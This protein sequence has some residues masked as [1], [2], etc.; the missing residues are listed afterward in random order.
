MGAG[1]QYHLNAA[2]KV[3]IGWIPA[4]NVLPVSAEGNYTIYPVEKTASGP[5]ALAIR[6]PDSNEEYYIDYRQPI[7]FD[8]TL[9]LGIISGASVI[10]TRPYQTSAT[11]YY[12]GLHT[13]RIDATPGDNDFTNS[14]L[15]DGK[16]FIDTMNGVTVTQ[17]SHNSTSATVNVKFGA[18]TC[19]KSLPSISISPA[20]QKGVSGQ[21]LNYVATIK[22]NDSAT[23]PNLRFIFSGAV[24]SGWKISMS[25]SELF[26][27]PGASGTVSVAVTSPTS[28][29]AGDYQ[30]IFNAVDYRNSQNKAS[31]S[32][33]Y[34]VAADTVLPSVAIKS[35]VS[36]S[37][38]SGTVD[39][40]AQVSDNVGVKKMEFYVN[41]VL[42]N[43]DLAAPFSYRWNTST[44]A[45]GNYVLTVKAYDLAGNSKLSDPIGVVVDS[46]YVDAVAPAVQISAPAAGSVVR[47]ITGVTAIASDN[48][49]VTKIEFYINGKLVSTDNAAD[50]Y[51]SWNTKS[52]ATPY[53][54]GNYSL[55]AKAYDVAGNI[56][57]SPAIGVT[58]NNNNS[59]AYSIKITTPLDGSNIS[60]TIAI[61]AQASGTTLY[62]VEYYANGALIGTAPGSP[63]CINWNSMG[64]PNGTYS[65]TAKLYNG[66]VNVAAISSPVSVNVS[67]GG[68]LDKSAPI[69]SLVAPA[70]SSTISGITDVAVSASDNNGVAGV[71]FFINGDLV[72]FDASAP[73]V[74]KWN[75][76][77][78]K[79]GNHIVYV[80]AYDA[81]GNVS[82][83]PEIMVNISNSLGAGDNTLPSV[84]L[85]LPANNSTVSGRT[86]IKATATDDVAV[87]QVFFSV[88]G[89]SIIGTLSGY[90]V[91]DNSWL[92]TGYKDGWHEVSALATDTS[93][94]IGRSR[95]STVFINNAISGDTV[96]TVAPTL[97]I[98]APVNNSIV[99][100][101]TNIT[102]SATDNVGV[103]K[104]EFYVDHNLQKIGFTAPYVYLWD[105]TK[106]ANRTHLIYALAYD[107]AGNIATLATINV[108]V[109]NKVSDTSSPTVNLTAPTNNTAY[110]T[111]QTVTISASDNVGVIKVEFY[112]NGNLLGSD[113]TNPYSYPWAIT[114]ANNGNHSLTAKAY[115]AAGNSAISSAVSVTVNIASSDTVAPTASIT[116]PAN[117]STVSG[118]ANVTA[119]ASDNV[120]V[121]K[122]EFYIDGALK[123]TDTASSYS[124]SWNTTSASNGAHLIYAKAYDAAGNVG[125]S[126]T[127][128]VTVSNMTS[129]TLSPTV[130]LTAPTNNIVYST[131]QTAIISATASDN[132]G[133]SKV[134]FYDNG[135]L[136]ASDTTNPYSYSWAI[137]SANNG[138]HS[139]TA[140]AYDAAGNSAVSSA[141]S[142]TVNIA[143]SD[144][145]APTA[146]ITAPANNGTVSGTANVS[147]TAS[148]NVGV[149]KVEFYIDGTLKTT[150]TSSPYSYSWNTT[151]LAN[152]AHSIYAKAYDAAGNAGT[153]ATISVNVSDTTST[154][155]S[156]TITS[157]AANSVVG[158]IVPINVTTANKSLIYDYTM[159]YIDGKYV[160]SAVPRFSTLSYS[161]NASGY[162]NGAHTI[163]VKIGSSSSIVAT[164]S[165]N[166]T[167]SN[168]VAGRMSLDEIALAVQNLRASMADIAKQLQY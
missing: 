127:I 72:F 136:L 19:K 34:S 77:L 114:S 7:G 135:N 149:I 162:A 28:A 15:S 18:G 132:V 83:T 21:A 46:S 14:A 26:L 91:L 156:A 96:D 159:L 47:G 168:A 76:A 74:Y 12:G 67:N 79:N 85:S 110:S 44:L 118:T 113:T 130:S 93:G 144:T 102:A 29:V 45:N 86:P 30:F 108:T 119:N 95:T 111:A 50:Y 133:V 37:R 146:S 157:P 165:I 115:D 142:V 64:V 116:A 90:S 1:G 22:N 53:P 2:H 109:N 40:A 59:V 3:A 128:S 161:W 54:D 5:Q 155:V 137:T 68:S 75:T 105:T 139:L 8:K 51:F 27:N 129:D 148:D 167:V 151:G 62:K 164:T 80:K 97:S 100:G 63:F 42:K 6:K 98:T 158:G 36:G 82:R 52:T 55:T 120:G 163:T 65:L 73:F 84:V 124:Y 143:T 23:C 103:T 101:T 11:P 81:A 160:A 41:G 106:L 43:E 78:A 58:V 145:T 94:N 33:A 141:V 25:S 66:N 60:G 99:S 89:D 153:A 71:E 140:K 48:L 147:A 24:P 123:T 152:G 104:V 32:G 134:E 154:A 121:I 35:P 122:V 4:S 117:N 70:D 87:K 31:A 13:E 38:V 112:D 61:D 39:I 88:D 17:V 92:T 125:T 138:A 10:L 16:S 20:A 56:G 57:V 107:A 49:L 9:P 126:A 131:A 166:V 69:V 150:D